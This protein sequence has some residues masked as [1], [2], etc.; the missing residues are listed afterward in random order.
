MLFRFRQAENID[1]KGGTKLVENIYINQQSSIRLK[2]LSQLLEKYQAHE[3]SINTAVLRDNIEQYKGL[4]G[5]NNAYARALMCLGDIRKH[6]KD[7]KVRLDFICDDLGIRSEPLDV[8]KTK[9]FQFLDYVN[10]DGIYITEA[11]YTDGLDVMAFDIACHDYGIGTD[12][13]IENAFSVRKANIISDNDISIL[14]EVANGVTFKDALS[15]KIG[16]T[17]Y[18]DS[19]MV[20]K[21]D[22]FQDKMG[23]QSKYRTMLLG[24]AEK[25]MAI[26]TEHVL[27]YIDAEGIKAR[28]GAVDNDSII[29]FTRSEA[30]QQR[31]ADGLKCSIGVVARGRK[32]IFNPEIRLY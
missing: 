3:Y 25:L 22:Y 15:L 26:I 10:S 23:K 14:K 5:Q 29:L 11:I 12:D 16:Y 24:S 4:C 21:V 17:S 32:F 28:L 27:E 7:G 13:E 6:M 30:E 20:D 9:Y 8:L 19:N 2:L 1:K 31:L 18:M